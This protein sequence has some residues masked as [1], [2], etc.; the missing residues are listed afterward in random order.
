[1]TPQEIERRQRA[2]FFARLDRIEAELKAEERESNRREFLAELDR[3]LSRLR[4]NSVRRVGAT[5]FSPAIG[6]EGVAEIE[7]NS[8]WEICGAS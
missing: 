4:K 1:M 3:L 5:G 7:S 8:A 2:R 6:H